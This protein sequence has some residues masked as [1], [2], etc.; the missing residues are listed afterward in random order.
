MAGRRRDRG[1]ARQ[2]TFA[3]ASERI[4][5]AS[6]QVNLGQDAAGRATPWSL[7]RRR[8]PRSAGAAPPP[9][10][11]GRALLPAA[12]LGRGLG[13]DAPRQPRFP[14]FD[15]I[16]SDV[17]RPAALELDRGAPAAA[18]IRLISASQAVAAASASLGRRGGCGCPEHGLAR[19]LPLH[20]A[21]IAGCLGARR[22]HVLVIRAVCARSRSAPR[23]PSRWPL[24]DSQR[25]S[26]RRAC[27]RMAVVDRW[28]ART[29]RRAA[30]GPRIDAPGSLPDASR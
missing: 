7:G 13:A 30:T 6:A 26:T 1:P 24:G 2:V 17:A 25:S 28:S 23:R 14:V 4:N 3:S 12:R 27:R 20:G 8:P 16:T 19:P 21:R 10:R 11:S 15:S 18:L 29:C 5:G 22:A 9:L